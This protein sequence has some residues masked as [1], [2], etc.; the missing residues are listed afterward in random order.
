MENDIRT[1]TIIIDQN[2]MRIIISISWR[3]KQMCIHRNFMKMSEVKQFETNK[4]TKP[5]NA[6][7]RETCRIISQIRINQNTKEKSNNCQQHLPWTKKQ[8]AH[9]VVFRDGAR[10]CAIGLCVCLLCIWKNHRRWLH[11]LAT[12]AQCDPAWASRHHRN[13]NI[14]IMINQRRSM[15]CK[16]VRDWRSGC[17]VCQCPVV[18]SIFVNMY[19]ACGFKCS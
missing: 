16:I 15:A 17:I 7:T 10:L 14:R 12:M 9:I 2:K 13:A 3:P 19:R 5:T 18:G 11:L 4:I 6:R 1:R 8:P